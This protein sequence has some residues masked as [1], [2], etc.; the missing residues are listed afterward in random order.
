MKR[1]SLF[2]KLVPIVFALITVIAGFFAV[3]S[4]SGVANSNVPVLLGVIFFLLV[5]VMGFNA[6]ARKSRL[7]GDTDCLSARIST[8]AIGGI[9]LFLII[10]GMGTLAL[11]G[12]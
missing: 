11:R 9:T 7:S 5:I 6:V 2:S 12:M 10:A 4:T 1:S 8:N 3:R